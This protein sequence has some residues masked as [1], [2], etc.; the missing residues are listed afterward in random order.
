MLNRTYIA[1]ITLKEESEYVNTG[2]LGE[3]IF[4]YW[5][6]NNFNDEI[7][8]KQKADR[9][10]DGI[11][12]VDEKG[13]KYQ[14]KTTRAKSYTFSGCKEDLDNKLNADFYVFVQIKKDA[15]LKAE[16]AYIEG[17]YSKEYVKKNI[18]N[19]FSTDTCFVYA[20][21]LLQQ[22]ISL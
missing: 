13:Y 17:F 10:Y 1:K 15:P 16:E 21:N 9:D 8:H 12:F 6:G 20:K 5:F 3:Q 2:L 4:K 7:L 11:D 18:V 22:E 19:S 14:V